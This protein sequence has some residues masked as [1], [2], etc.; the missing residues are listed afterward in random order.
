MNLTEAIKTLRPAERF[1]ALLF[2]GL[3]SAITSITTSWL[4]QSDCKGISD[5]Y[6]EL[7]QNQTKIMKTNNEIL[8]DNTA[9]T[10]DIMRL[11]RIIEK[12]SEEQ[13]T[14]QMVA[15]NDKPRHIVKEIHN[16]DGVMSSAPPP[17]P[18][19]PI[20]RVIKVTGISQ[21]QKSLLDSAME[22]T[23]KYKK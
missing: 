1:K 16:G 17:P 12:I 3:L 22:I 6:Q 7:V 20:V 9:K 13:P 4:K 23:K 2:I 18:S 10:E 19:E 14:Q 5:Q 11:H 8:A 21:K 15:A